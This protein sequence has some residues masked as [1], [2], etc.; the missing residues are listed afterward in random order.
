MICAKV[1][2]VQVITPTP[3]ASLKFQSY[4]C[5]AEIA[6]EQYI[7]SLI[8]LEYLLVKTAFRQGSGLGAVRRRLRPVVPHAL[9]RAG[10]WRA[11]RGRR[12]R[13]RRVRGAAEDQGARHQRRQVNRPLCYLGIASG[14]W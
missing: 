13:V 6:A 11:A 12:V 4:G 8:S 9:R 10:A 2:L 5:V 14:E 3:C 1:Q 7:G